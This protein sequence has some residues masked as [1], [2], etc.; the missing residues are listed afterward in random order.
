MNQKA[1]HVPESTRL[2]KR[3]S[4]RNS[5]R[6]GDDETEPIP[7]EGGRRNAQHPWPRIYPDSYMVS[8]RY[9]LPGGD[10][11]TGIRARLG[12]SVEGRLSPSTN[13][14]ER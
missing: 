14:Q 7:A 3:P 9:Q 12:P 10:K 11:E 6:Y 13:M 8:M 2:R 5:A 4:N 1:P